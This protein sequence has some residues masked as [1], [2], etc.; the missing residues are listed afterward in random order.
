L[1]LFTRVA[2]ADAELVSVD[3]PGGAGGGGYP[4]RK[5]ALYQAFAMPGQRLELIR[6][7][8]HDPAVRDRVA[9]LFGERGVDFLFID[10]NHSYEGVR[11]DF[12]M[13]GPL[14]APDGLIAFHDIDY[15][16]DVRRFWDEVKVGRRWQEIRGEHG[17]V[18]GIGLI[19][20]QAQAV[21]GVTPSP[22]ALAASC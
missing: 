11:R 18:F 3:L 13:Y 4:A 14:V 12:E 10:G 1:F 2:A 16:D 9:G 5:I 8:S 22:T 17:Q 6:D 19:H 21:A 7:D 20:G 15:C